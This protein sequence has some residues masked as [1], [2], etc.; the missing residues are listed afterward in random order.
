M[1]AASPLRFDEAIEAAI[2]TVLISPYTTVKEISDMCESLSTP[3]R[4]VYAR[5][6]SCGGKPCAYLVRAS[7]AESIP[8]FLRRQAGG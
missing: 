6:E 2:N 1:N 5:I 7:S 3:E 8:R 4:E